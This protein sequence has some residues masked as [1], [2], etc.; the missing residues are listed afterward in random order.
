[1]LKTVGRT[2][3]GIAAYRR[4]LALDPASGDA[5]WGLANLKSGA[6]D[7]ADVERMMR[8][9]DDGALGLA[10]RINLHFALGRALEE[11]G[12]AQASFRH[13]EAGN[14]LQRAASPYDAAATTAEAGKAKTLFTPA[15]FAARAGYGDPRRS[16]SSS[17]ACRAPARR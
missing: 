15:F 5:W 13:Y 3:E 8:L 1:M 9:L 4:A 10:D 6:L 2:E 12:E 16:R 14:S 7:A 11:A 17:S